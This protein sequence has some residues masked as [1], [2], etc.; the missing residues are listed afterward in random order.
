MNYNDQI[1]ERVVEAYREANGDGEFLKQDV[2]AWAIKTGTWKPSLKS[3]IEL[4][5]DEISTAMRSERKVV[6]G[7][8]VR[9]YHCIVRKLKSGYTQTVWAHIDVASPE[10]MEQSVALRRKNIGNKVFQLHSDI[11][12]WNEYKN[13]ARPIEALFDFRDDIADREQAIVLG[14]DQDDEQ[15]ELV[16]AEEAQDDV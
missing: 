8:N 16:E 4:L 1:I 14:Q 9:Q 7:R 13:P 2:A 6:N 10:F 11:V 12:Y 15:G 5:S 3:Q